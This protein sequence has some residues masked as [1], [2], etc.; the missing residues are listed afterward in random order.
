[1]LSQSA[2]IALMTVALLFTGCK[3]ESTVN[4]EVSTASSG[5]LSPAPHFELRG[6]TTGMTHDQVI[7]KAKENG[8]VVYADKPDEI[9]I[10]EPGA[11]T[12][13]GGGAAA[14]K[15]GM[16][17]EIDMSTLTGRSMI[18]LGG[19]AGDFGQSILQSAI[20][21]WG[22]PT[23]LNGETFWGDRNGI[24]AAYAYSPGGMSPTRLKI[25][26]HVAVNTQYDHDHPPAAGPKL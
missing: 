12:G 8:M 15:P 18:V 14:V 10:K 26:D 20:Q 9:D 11:S 2:V 24:H 23:N 6:F 13:P 22:Q 5:M 16:L 1:M 17:M 21:K 7:S 3:S 25:V 19:M 4:A